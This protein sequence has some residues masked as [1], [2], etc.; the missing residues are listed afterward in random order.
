M[1]KEAFL[2]QLRKCLRGLPQK[3]LEEQLAFYREMIDDRIEEGLTE[4]EA[5]SAVGSVEAIAAQT[6]A[7]IP[8]TKLAKE[9]IKPRRQLRVWEII[10]LVLGSPI[11][12]SLLISALAVV[13]SLYISLWAVVISLWAVFVSLI[14]CGVAGILVGIGFVCVGKIPSGIA[15]IGGAFVC[16]GLAIF[17]F[18][19]CCLATKGTV[20]LAKMFLLWIK[21]CFI[22]KEGA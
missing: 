6:V 16:G 13:L 3:D 20:L 19:G 7:E 10:L 2:E 5:V 4:E 18:Y 12:L 9:R 8:L 11:W 15:V 14:A 1:G 17:L 21:R 22:R